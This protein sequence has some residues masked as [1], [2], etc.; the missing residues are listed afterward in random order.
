[1][2]FS[3]SAKRSF[4]LF[5]GAFLFCALLRSFH[6]TMWLQC[7]A[8]LYCG[9]LML[10]WAMSVQKRV[11]D[12]H[13]RSLL[14]GVAGMELLFLLLQICKYDLCLGH[15]TIG[16]YCWYGYYVPM[17]GMSV[18]CWLIAL[19]IHRPKDKPLAP[20]ALLP[21]ALGGA[22]VLLIL[23]N[24]LHGLA[25]S[26]PDKDLNQYER[27][28]FGI[29]YALFTSFCA[30][31]IGAAFFLTLRKSRRA[32]GAG[33]RMMPA[34]PILIMAGLLAM[35]VLGTLPHLRNTSKIWNIGEIFGFGMIGFLE[36]CIQ[37]GL[38][39]AN[40]EYE[41]FFRTMELPAV[42]MDSNG[43]VA[44]RSAGVQGPLTESEDMKLLSQPIAGGSV[45]MAVDVSELRKLNEQITA[46]TRQIEAR[47]EYL[48]AENRTKQERT[49]LET[50][51]ALYDRI[52][53][54][55]W[56]QLEEIENK[57]AAQDISAHL[58]E[59]AVLCAYVKRRSNME[60][61]AASDNLGTDELILALRESME[62]VSLCGVSTAVRA[63]GNGSYVPGLL[64]AAYEQAERV[65]EQSLGGAK[66]IMLSVQAEEEALQLR[67]LIHGSK[68][69]LPGP[70]S[71]VGDGFSFSRSVEWDGEEGA[72]TLRFAPKG[73]LAA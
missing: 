63:S 27:H 4:L 9:S 12:G 37:V 45:C 14:L 57:L 44:E 7:V 32:L 71:G 28:S 58:G 43:E 66:S 70:E 19:S 25:F 17:M 30:A 42:I 11:T 13:L 21:A 8:Q 29:G 73:G 67:L 62:Y 18:L 46:A 33:E 48:A 36:A 64:T 69:G 23:T 52:V 40:R 6:F 50:R 22:L 1:M 53:G 51:N 72:I 3:T 10:V 2:Y 26:F 49:E 39:P 38:I 56:P 34:L 15:V 41:R 24:D 65:I 60:L 54:L 16:R 5:A 61:L 55:T 68:P 20:A 47:N 31:A 59:I 35:D